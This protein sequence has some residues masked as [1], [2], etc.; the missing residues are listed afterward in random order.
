VPLKD[1]VAL[2][3]CLY[4]IACVSESRQ[5]VEQSLHSDQNAPLLAMVVWRK[6]DV[7][8]MMMMV[9]VLVVM[10]MIMMMISA[11][12]LCVCEATM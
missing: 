5:S 1:S 8:R 11:H 2:S 12:A 6:R 7:A 10:T 3:V 4:E 9:V